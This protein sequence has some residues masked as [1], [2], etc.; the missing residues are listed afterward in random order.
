ME[1]YKELLEA[2]I[3]KELT[4]L[5]DL[6]VILALIVV[7]IW[8]WCF[9]YFK[10]MKKRNLRLYNT[11]KQTKARRQS[12]YASVALTAV[13]A[14][15]GTFFCFDTANIIA[16]IKK[17][18]SLGE[19]ITYDGRYFVDSDYMRY[20]PYDRWMSVDFDNGDY[21][22]L[23]MDN[24]F[25]FIKTEEGEFEGSVVYAKNS[26]IVVDMENKG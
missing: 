4:V 19:F 26:L 12:V 3:R 1:K 25:E 5:I 11:E 13:C 6:T 7:F 2:V 15:L 10:R 8:V 16:D 23:Y 20:A 22:Y 21:A 17:D 18:I 9:L 14:L 24:I